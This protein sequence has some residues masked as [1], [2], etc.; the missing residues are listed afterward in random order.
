MVIYLFDYLICNDK[1]Y[2]FD[3]IQRNNLVTCNS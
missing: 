3:I 1:L 2:A